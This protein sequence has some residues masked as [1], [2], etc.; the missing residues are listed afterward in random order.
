MML[1]HWC[2]I[3]NNHYYLKRFD[4]IILTSTTCSNLLAGSG[5]K[6]VIGYEEA[7]QLAWNS[8]FPH[9]GL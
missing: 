6:V 1:V 5:N 9:A 4:S 3:T 8:S 7:V 2:L